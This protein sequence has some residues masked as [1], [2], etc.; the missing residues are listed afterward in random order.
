METKESG[1]KSGSK[2]PEELSVSN[3]WDLIKERDGLILMQS[4]KIETLEQTVRRLQSENAEM[5]KT[6]MNNQR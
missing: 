3:L 5:R 1:T 6:L 4:Q 2:P